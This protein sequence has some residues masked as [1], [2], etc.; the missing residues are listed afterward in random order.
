LVQNQNNPK[1]TSLFPRPK[2]E[3]GLEDV[4]LRKRSGDTKKAKATEGRADMQQQG[5]IPVSSWRQV[6]GVCVSARV[7]AC[8]KK[9]LLRLL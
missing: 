2:K 4:V 6:C 8:E 5:E 9:K 1:G 7:A 3:G